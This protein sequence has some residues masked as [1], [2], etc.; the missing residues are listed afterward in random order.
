MIGFL[1]TI[2]CRN[3]IVTDIA[4]NVEIEYG[5]LIP[6]PK[7]GA[8][9]LIAHTNNNGGTRRNTLKNSMKIVKI[10]S[11]TPINISISDQLSA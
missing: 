2:D 7:I 11:I 6:H 3:I 5:I 10:K 8:S 1:N 9:V 4:N